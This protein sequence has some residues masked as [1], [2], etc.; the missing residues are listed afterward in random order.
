MR[1]G[2]YWPKMKEDAK[3]LVRTCLKCQ[4]HAN[5]HYFP[6]NQYHIFWYA[7]SICI[8]GIDLLGPFPKALAR[9]NH[10][11]VAF[12]HFTKWIEIKALSSITAKKVKDFFYKDIIYRFGIPKL[13]SDNGK[14]FDS[15][16]F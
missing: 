13:I 15:K 2:Y 8:V 11:V 1:Y 3:N 9:K 5:E 7:N 16:K 14:Q 12:N 6:M 4:V 10:L